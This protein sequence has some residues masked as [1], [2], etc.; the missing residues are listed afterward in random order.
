MV[1]VG[2]GQEIF[3]QLSASRLGQSWRERR[4][5]GGAELVKMGLLLL[6][7]LLCGSKSCIV[8]NI[9][10]LWEKADG[11]LDREDLPIRS[12]LV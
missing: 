11:C 5:S 2:G 7:L 10:A 12:E 3:T 1:V 6:L 9:D 8:H 4:R